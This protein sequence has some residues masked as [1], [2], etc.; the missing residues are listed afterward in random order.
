MSERTI[1]NEPVV[2]ISQGFFEPTLLL[3]VSTRLQD[4]RETLEPAL[5]ALRGLR[6]IVVDRG[7][8]RFGSE[9][10]LGTICLL[11]GG[12]CLRRTRQLVSRDGRMAG[13]KGDQAIRI[14]IRQRAQQQHSAVQLAGDLANAP[15]APKNRV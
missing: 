8:R 13:P 14:G 11:A 10:V 15:V 6:R 1:R 12:G 9:V 3:S 4:G 5:S 7:V 2:R